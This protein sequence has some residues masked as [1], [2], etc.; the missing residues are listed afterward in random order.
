VDVAAIRSAQ[1]KPRHAKPVDSPDVHRRALQP[2]KS[3]GGSCAQKRPRHR[4]NPWLKLID[5]VLADWA[6]TSRAA[7]LLVVLALVVLA[8]TR[9]VSLG[10]ALWLAAMGVGMHAVSGPLARGRIVPE[11]S[12]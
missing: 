8:G 2:S 5:S 9:A 12:A 3:A 7:V 11:L 10:F 6:R 4:G 1:R